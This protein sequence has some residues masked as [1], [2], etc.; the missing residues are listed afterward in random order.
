MFDNHLDHSPLVGGLL[1]PQG[2][3]AQVQAAAGDHYDHDD[4]EDDEDHEDY[5]LKKF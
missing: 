5:A 4:L 2:V 1:L 3:P